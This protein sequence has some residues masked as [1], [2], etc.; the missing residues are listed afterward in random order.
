M[1]PVKY[2]AENPVRG[3]TCYLSRIFWNTLLGT[4]HLDMEN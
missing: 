2:G 1:G 4:A 3:A